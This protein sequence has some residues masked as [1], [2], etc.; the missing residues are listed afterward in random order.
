MTTLVAQRRR[1]GLAGSAI[2][3]GSI[4][5]N[6]YVIQHLTKG[7]QEFFGHMGNVAMSEQD[8]H[9]IFAKESSQATRPRAAFRKS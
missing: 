3:L 2:N 9:Q 6:G 8:F 4:Y 5:G 7:Q 1:R